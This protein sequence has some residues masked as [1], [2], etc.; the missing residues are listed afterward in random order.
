MTVL[1][2]R[3][4]LVAE[5][6]CAG[7]MVADIGS[8]HAQLALYLTEQGVA[9]RVIATE[10]GE[11]P[12]SRACR[13]VQESPCR[14]RIELRRGNGLQVLLPG[15][16]DEVV[17]AGMGGDTII[18]IL[19]YDWNKA[20]SFQR[21]LF[22]PMSRARTVRANLAEQGWPIEDERLVR[23]KNRIYVV[24][25]ARPGHSPYSLSPLELEVGPLI[26]GADG[27]LKREYISAILHQMRTAHQQMMHS[28]RDDIMRAAVVNLEIIARLE[29]ILDASHREG[30]S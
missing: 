4:S 3:L 24:I 9:P 25:A 27:E 19:G 11:G 2:E 12:F 8:D 26:L 28:A 6:I 15:E 20:A 14:E 5:M 1:R 29:E 16:V 21:F 17:M 22:Q 13:L 7:R 10:L 18:D 23:E 30:Y